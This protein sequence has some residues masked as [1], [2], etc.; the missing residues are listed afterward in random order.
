M[1][2]EVSP[3][4]E[5]VLSDTTDHR[6][7]GLVARFA[8]VLEVKRPSEQEPSG[9]E[10]WLAKAYAWANQTTA[11]ETTLAITGAREQMAPAALDPSSEL[12]L[13]VDRAHECADRIISETA[14]Y[15][16][17][18]KDRLKQEFHLEAEFFDEPTIVRFD[19]GGIIDF[20]GFLL[21]QGDQVV[22]NG[23]F[24]VTVCL[25]QS[26]S[27]IWTR[28]NDVRDNHGGR[29]F[30]ER[31][32][33]IDLAQQWFE[34]AIAPALQER[35]RSTLAELLNLSEDSLEMKPANHI[36]II[37]ED[38]QSHHL[39]ALAEALKHGDDVQGH[40]ELVTLAAQL[41]AIAR[42]VPGLGMDGRSVGQLTFQ[43]PNDFSD[44]RGQHY[45][46]SPKTTRGNR[47]VLI[48]R[49]ERNAILAVGLASDEA[50]ALV[51]VERPAKVQ[52]DAENGIVV[53]RTERLGPKPSGNLTAEVANTIAR[54][55]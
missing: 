44:R 26:R 42:E 28:L 37:A 41:D 40:Q 16:K 5:N 2:S 43:T 17:S 46:I 6:S 23:R 33:F 19:P 22:A 32:K 51:T 38:V 39:G 34:K 7:G 49:A 55:L 12:V 36:T 14:S 3:T 54:Y 4:I 18:V 9:S 24:C 10:D 48:C 29:P 1:T 35:Y 13:G 8:H 31:R 21:R 15:T 52:F 30:A 25:H 20:P 27:K 11:D 53:Q 50:R 47:G 45:L